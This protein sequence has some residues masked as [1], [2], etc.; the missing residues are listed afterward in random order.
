MAA[1]AK[2]PEIQC[3]REDRQSHRKNLSGNYWNAPGDKE[4]LTRILRVPAG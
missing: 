1:M 3:S 2:Y 4:L